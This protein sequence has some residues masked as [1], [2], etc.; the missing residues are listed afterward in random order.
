MGCHA[1]LQGIFPTQGSNLCLLLCLLHWQ[2][3]SLPPAVP[4]KP[5]SHLPIKYQIALDEEAPCS[6]MSLAWFSVFF[7]WLNFFPEHLVYAVC[8]LWCLPGCLLEY[9]PCEDKVLISFMLRCWC[10]A[11][12][13]GHMARVLKGIRTWGGTQKGPGLGPRLVCLLGGRGPCLPVKKEAVGALQRVNS[14]GGQVFQGVLLVFTW[15]PRRLG[16]GCPS[17][18]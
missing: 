4:G 8:C 14:F 12:A 15:R 5:L 16:P 11:L 9:R 17:A 2:A 18:E 10:P 1:F 13:H 6:Y 3:G 7:T